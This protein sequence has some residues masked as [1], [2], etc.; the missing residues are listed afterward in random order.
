MKFCVCFELMEQ[1]DFYFEFEIL[2]EFNGFL[3][4]RAAPSNVQQQVI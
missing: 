1:E 2:T 3:F 4:L